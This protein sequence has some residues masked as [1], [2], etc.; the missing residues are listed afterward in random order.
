MFWETSEEKPSPA[1]IDGVLQ[2]YENMG[3]LSRLSGMLIGRPYAYDD[4]WRRELPEVVSARTE[5]YDFPIVMG[6]DFGHTA[7]Q[8][9]LPIGCRAEIDVAQRRFAILEAAVTADR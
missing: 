1:W 6:M 3:V 9:T 8:M 2:D 4:A 5:R 7:P